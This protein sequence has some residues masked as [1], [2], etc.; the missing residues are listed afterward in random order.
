[1]SA[2][3]VVHLAGGWG[4]RAICTDRVTAETFYTTPYQTA[5]K[6]IVQCMY[7]I[8]YNLCIMGITK[9]QESVMLI[10]MLQN[11]SSCPLN[12][13]SRGINISGGKVH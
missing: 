1:M 5:F 2:F 12:V 8:Q 7:T 4:V 3:P 6:Y 13:V 10:S 9:I 11:V